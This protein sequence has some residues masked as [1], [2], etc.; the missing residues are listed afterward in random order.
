MMQWCV[1]C[2]FVFLKQ[3]GVM[4]AD[5]TY[6]STENEACLPPLAGGGL[7]VHEYFLKGK[8]SPE[9][10][11]DGLF[12]SKDYVAVVDGATSK[13]LFRLEGKTPGRWAM[14]LAIEAIGKFP[15]DLTVQDAVARLTDRL[16]AFYLSHNLMELV[17]SP[18]YRFAA[19]M[20]IFSRFRR[21]IWQIGDCP[22]YFDKTRMS[23]AKAIDA[24]MADARSAYNE[25]FLL[26][27]GTLAALQRH[28]YGRDFI[29]P[30]LK[31][32]AAF[33]NCSL[34]SSSYA[35]PVIDG[36]PVPL[37]LVKVHPV[38]SCDCIVLGSDGYPLLFSTLRESERYLHEVLEKDPCCIS[39]FKS[40]KGIVGGN[41]SF[42]DRAYI[43]FSVD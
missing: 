16:H 37:E 41:S 43:R 28:D 19:C 9:T 30:L 34:A 17:A 18:M 3:T 12:A 10:N 15:V 31:R 26:Q 14:E 13:S 39:L 40:T 24:L 2:I 27:G 21:E 11:E 38:S 20:V 5:W 36:F 35:F 32:Q 1:F 23:N 29:L 42:D 6:L 7:T 8:H 4:I 33:Q 25:A 22:C